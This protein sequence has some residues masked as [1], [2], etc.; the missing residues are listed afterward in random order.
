[1]IFEL[2]DKEK[3]WKLWESKDLRIDEDIS[4]STPGNIPRK[5]VLGNAV[6]RFRLMKEKETLYSFE[7]PIEIN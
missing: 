3:T 4:F 6:V 7:I 2:S 1:M 5:A